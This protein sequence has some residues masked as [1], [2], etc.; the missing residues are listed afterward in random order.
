[1]A[2][3]CG[4]KEA[5]P[6]SLQNFCCNW[7][8][9]GLIGFLTS[10]LDWD[11]D[12]VQQQVAHCRGVAK[13]LPNSGST[14]SCKQIPQGQNTPATPGCPQRTCPKSSGKKLDALDSKTLWV[15]NRDTAPTY[16]S[17]QNVRNEQF[18][19]AGST[20]DHA[21]LLL[22]GG[23]QGLRLGSIDDIIRPS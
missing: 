6:S 7:N 19:A 4:S 10:M 5:E 14:P 3:V 13:W 11:A 1:M 20:P 9:V 21:K 15:A 23:L 12:V 8:H 16:T 2:Y 22:G 17:E 18:L